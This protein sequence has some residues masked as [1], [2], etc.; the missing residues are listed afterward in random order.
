MRMLLFE[1]I[2]NMFIK[3]LNVPISLLIDFLRDIDGA[4]SEGWIN[5]YI[6]VGM[7]KYLL[8]CFDVKRGPGLRP[9]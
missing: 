3:A 8:I 1:M 4:A 5:C 7:Q 6:C 2:T 9:G